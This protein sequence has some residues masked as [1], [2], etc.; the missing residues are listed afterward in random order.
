LARSGF[1]VRVW[2][3]SIERAKPLAE[4]GAGVHEDV[5]EAL[6]GAELM[7]T[8]LSDADSVLEVAGSALE[9]LDSGAIWIQMSTIGLEGIK[10][11]QTLADD[12]GVTLVDAPVLGTREPAEQAKLVILAS[13]PV[14]AV[15][16]CHPIFEAIG[17]RTLELGVAGAG[18]RCKVVVNSW[19]VGVVGVLAETVTLAEGL[20]LEPQR[21]F[22]AVGGGP[23]DLPYAR[24]KGKQML[25]RSFD[26]PAFR[27]ALS[28]KDADLVLAAAA[29]ARLELPIMRATTE[30]LRRVE[31]EGH[32][33]EDMSATYWASAPR[34]GVSS[35]EKGR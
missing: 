18:T 28:R 10:R 35:D 15:A 16:R 11:C 4:D 20:E 33:D 27:L 12:A 32:G 34:A 1:E 5:A 29:E 23:L 22:E 3:R 2:N 24:I 26:D 7:V 19:I 21:F 13:G 25:E 31:E 8:M 17:Q 30:R 6:R 14:E 9:R